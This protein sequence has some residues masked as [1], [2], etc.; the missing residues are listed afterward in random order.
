MATPDV[1][2][3]ESASNETDEE[4]CNERMA[5]RSHAAAFARGPGIRGGI[6]KG[7]LERQRESR[8]SIDRAAPRG[9]GAGRDRQSGQAGRHRAGEFVSCLVGKGQSATLD[10]GG[11]HQGGG[12]EIDGGEC[13]VVLQAG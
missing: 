11:S 9:G 12:A 7:G 13:A 2:R 8:G 10:A 1:T 6:S 3:G 4:R 5:R